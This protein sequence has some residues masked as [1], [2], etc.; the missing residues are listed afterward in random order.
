MPVKKV[1]K[2]AKPA[3]KTKKETKNKHYRINEGQG[4][5]LPCDH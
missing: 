3:K 5:L 4:S 1:E 2:K